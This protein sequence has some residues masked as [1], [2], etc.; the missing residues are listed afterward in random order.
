M[1]NRIRTWS[2]NRSIVRMRMRKGACIQGEF[3]TLSLEHLHL[4]S[5][6][7]NRR[8]GQGMPK[9]PQSI[10][11]AGCYQEKGALSKPC[12]GSEAEFHSHYYD[13][14]SSV[15]EVLRHYEEFNVTSRT[16]TLTLKLQKGPFEKS[17]FFSFNQVELVLKY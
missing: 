8:N 7:Y 3:S 2:R 17:F 9:I 13:L 5:V 16:R 15:L 10:S 4:W 11:G 14:H 1:L 12:H 6:H